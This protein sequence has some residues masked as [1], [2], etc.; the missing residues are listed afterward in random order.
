MRALDEARGRA[1]R[2]SA[3]SCWGRSPEAHLSELV[4][5]TLHCSRREAA[6]L[7]RLVREKTGGNPF[8]AIQFL[9]A[10]HRRAAD[11]VR[12]RHAVAGAG[13]SRAIRAQG[14]T[15]NVV[16]LMVGKLHD[17]PAET[18]EALKLAACLG[19][20]VDGRR[21][22]RRRSRRDPARRAARGVEEDLLLRM[23][24]TLSLPHD[25]VQ[26][27]AYSLIPESE[28]AAVH[29]RHR[30]AAA[31]AHAARG[32]RR[33]DLRDRR[34]AQSRRGADHVGATERERVA[35]LNL[36]A[37]KRASRSTRLRSALRYFAAGAALLRSGRA[38]SAATSSPSRS[39]C[40]GP[41]ASS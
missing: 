35:E 2:A 13:T 34:P 11:R 15:D 39:S 23:D 17:L 6:P 1:A 28:R 4:A 40:T 21:A 36:L 16:E 19:A 38:G 3:T 33:A 5:D 26:E 31:G 14:F 27:A 24:G 37:G 18:Q 25:R 22:G 7:A 30:P 12:P 41:S 8:F 29:L 32:A 20:S 9:T 10:L